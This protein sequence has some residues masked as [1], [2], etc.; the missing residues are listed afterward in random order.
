MEKWPDSWRC[1]LPETRRFRGRRLLQQLGGLFFLASSILA[2]WLHRHDSGLRP[3]C[4]RAAPR[5]PRTSSRA[6]KRLDAYFDGLRAQGSSS[7]AAI[8]ISERGVLRYQ[9][10]IGFA[11]HRERRAATRGRRHALSH[12][13]R[14]ADVHRGAD[15]AAREQARSRS[16]TSS[17]NSIPT[18]RTRSASPIASCCSIAAVSRTTSMRADFATWRT[19]P[20]THADMLAVI[21]AG[22][23]K[24]APARTD[25]RQ[26]TPTIYCWVTCSRRSRSVRTTTSCG[27]RSRASSAW[28][29]PTTPA[30]AA[31]PRSKA[32]HTGGPPK[33]G[34]PRSA[35][36]LRSKAARAAW[37]PTPPIS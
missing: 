34:A 37:C 5:T 27:G 19:T 31:R 8:A 18:C 26:T 35:R 4:S 13:R 9:R 6:T 7:T 33:A 16:T 30:P 3:C 20:R 10:S 21:D 32:F 36:I 17:R 24:F 11:T 15:A 22:G 25:R 12:R 1:R 2:A 29:A 28:C 23:A 14:D